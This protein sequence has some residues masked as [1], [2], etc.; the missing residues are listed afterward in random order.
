SRFCIDCGKPMTASAAQ[1]G[2]RSGAAATGG[3]AQ[4]AAAQGLAGT[5]S[6]TVP[7]RSGIPT[8]ALAA[9]PTAVASQP[10]TPS[11]ARATSVASRC[12]RCTKPADNTLA[13]CGYCGT[14]IAPAGAGTCAQC[15]ASYL[16]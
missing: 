15:G 16:Q 8:P 9:P 1:V 14:R 2:A 4:H 5:A 10:R 7:P 3:D 6:A 11:P 13:F 12:P